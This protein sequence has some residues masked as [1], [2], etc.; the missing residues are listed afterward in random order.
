MQRKHS[1][2]KSKVVST[3]ALSV[4]VTFRPVFPEMLKLNPQLQ[5]AYAVVRPK[6]LRMVLVLILKK[7]FSVVLARC[8][9][10]FRTGRK[11]GKVEKRATIKSAIFSFYNES[12]FDHSPVFNNFVVL[13]FCIAPLHVN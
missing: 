12:D 7:S 1:N 13:Y 2:D 6:W 11:R 3:L 8:E 4:F 10:M 5:A 9:L